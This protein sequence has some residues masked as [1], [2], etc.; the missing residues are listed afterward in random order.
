MDCFACFATR[1]IV[2]GYWYMYRIFFF[3]EVL[4]VARTNFWNNS[5]CIFRWKSQEMLWQN[6]IHLPLWFL[7]LVLSIVYVLGI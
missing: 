6:G 7:D 4:V 1:W 5:P 3:F 2:V